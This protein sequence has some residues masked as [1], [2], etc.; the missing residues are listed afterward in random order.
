MEVK[1]RVNRGT[2]FRERIVELKEKI[3]S[4]IIRCPVNFLSAL[5]LSRGIILGSAAPFGLAV[6]AVLSRG[7]G[8]V[9]GLLGSAIGY[10]S[11]FDRIN[12]LKYIAC[13]ILIFT[14]HFVF[15]ETSLVKSRLF[16]PIAV[17]IPST[18]INFVFLAD[19]SFPLFDCALSILETSLAAVCT[20]LFP[21][22]LTDSKCTSQIRLISLFTVCAAFIVP[23]CDVILFKSFSVGRFIAFTLVLLCAYSGG[24][25]P[26]TLC[27][28]VFGFTVALANSSPDFCML[29]AILGICVSALSSKNRFL[30]AAISAPFT[31]FISACLNTSNFIPCTMELL[32]ACIIFVTL[33]PRFNHVTRRF[34]TKY[35]S[36]HETHIRSY[37][38]AR[39]TAASQAFG[40]LG[41]LIGENRH[42]RNSKAPC[43][44]QDF[45]KH[46]TSEL[47]KKCTLT[48][49]CWR[50]DFEATRDALNNAVSA[51]RKNG[52]LSVKDFP[53]FFSSRCLHIEDFVNNV[54]REIFASRYREHF[55][56]KLRES[57]EL[58]TKQYSEAS[59]IFRSISSDISDNAHFDEEAE[60]SLHTLLSSHGVLCDV[61]VYRNAAG[62]INI[63]ICGKDL[64][65]VVNSFEHLRPYFEKETKASLGTPIL[66]HTD[67]L[68]DIVIREKPPLRAVFGAA[69]RSKQRAVP[70][71]DSGSF[72]RPND[73]C[74]ALLLSDGMGS[75]KLAARES[76]ISVSIL[77]TLLR[78]GIL[79]QSA[80][81]TLQAA[82]TLKSEYTGS[83][84]TLDLMYGNLFTGEC[85]FYKFGGAPTYIK[86]GNRLRRITSS[87]LPAGMSLN[88]LACPDKTSLTLYEGDFVIMTSD[89]ISDSNDDGKLLEFLSK[90]EDSSPKALADAILAF[91]LA[92]YEKNDDMTVAVIKI[93]REE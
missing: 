44:E 73:G 81:L 75:G 34:F 77:E 56:T 29:Y 67:S 18:C 30:N 49:I 37:A 55:D 69:S 6:S 17:I 12:S 15:A 90:A 59:A 1:N 93:E 84:A 13:I 9:F 11:V 27:G 62:H 2:A 41:K 43:S 25:G 91:S 78:T 39:L 89:G 61:A 31:L 24:I 36:T 54:N 83:F 86:R 16:S 88:G 8:A 4:Y 85:D 38:A 28:V 72:F 20:V 10:L 48:D 53:M 82:L 35:K 40:T 79:P 76:A 58:L 51:V 47:C 63:H 7:Y 26:G 60:L 57:R 32:P 68:D 33:A 14:A 87:S 45:F 42:I 74:V 80:L 71:G 50:R 22:S 92:V 52:T 65:Y 19:A 70:S 23:L 46:T 3:P 64:S 21:L 66:T 5:F